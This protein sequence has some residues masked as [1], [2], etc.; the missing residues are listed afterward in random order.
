MTEQELNELAD[1]I[2]A[3]IGER[4][5]A[6]VGGRRQ[7]AGGSIGAPI[8]RGAL[9]LKPDPTGAADIA[10]RGPSAKTAAWT[11]EQGARRVAD[12]VDHT[13][14]KAEATKAEIVKL[15][16]EAKEHRFA[17]VCV[18]PTWVELCVKELRGTEVAVATVVGFPLGATT[19]RAKAF[20]AREAVATGAGEIDMVA[21]IGRIKS[22]LWQCVEDDIREVALASRPALVKVIIESAVLTTE[23]IIKVSALAKEAGANFVKTSTGFHPAGG[24][25]V[26]AVRL[27]RL[28]V[29]DDLG[30]KASGG[31]RDCQ[32]ALA[33]IAA[34]ANRIGTS[35]GVGM[36]TCLGP[37][38]L[39]LAELLKAPHA[40]GAKCT[41]GTCESAGG[42]QY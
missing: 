29:G 12:F 36:V 5:G 16:A 42:G 22:G 28:V 18:N 21:A 13:L 34:G 15:C 32:T 1:E 17:A 27:M 9:A 24:A 3:R 7:A 2:V 8:V 31:V 20:E 26:Q 14:L 33:M 35:S 38:P 10:W 37:G 41:S 19:R 39:P 11:P 4:R 40:H 23:E 30:V 25:S 6:R